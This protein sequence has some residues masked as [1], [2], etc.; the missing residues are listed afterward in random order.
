VAKIAAGGAT[1]REIARCL[2]LSLTTVEMHW[3]GVAQGITL[4]L[5]RLEC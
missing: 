2:Y 4:R 1:N 5:A 3:R